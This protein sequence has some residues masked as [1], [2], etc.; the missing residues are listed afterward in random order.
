VR[1]AERLSLFRHSELFCSLCP[2]LPSAV[3]N[4]LKTPAAGPKPKQLARKGTRLRAGVA[5]ISD[6]FVQL[7]FELAEFVFFSSQLQLGLGFYRLTLLL[8][9]CRGF[10]IRLDTFDRLFDLRRG[11]VGVRAS[12]SQCLISAASLFRA[13]CTSAS[14]DRASSRCW[15][16]RVTATSWICKRASRIWALCIFAI[17]TCRTLRSSRT[18]V[19]RVCSVCESDE[20]A[21][22]KAASA[23][24]RNKRMKKHTRR[25]ANLLTPDGKIRHNLRRPVG[26]LDRNMPPFRRQ[27]TQMGI[28]D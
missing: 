27:R 22:P 14:L 24:P 28:G 15:D 18:S 23:I 21:W 7:T 13:S 26:K 11:L 8:K 12:S 19:N 5:H 1:V 25:I 4:A 16:A 9:V 10:H 20:L 6:E 17:E 2:S 3:I